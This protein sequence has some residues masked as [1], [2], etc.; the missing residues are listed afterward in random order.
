[1]KR[2]VIAILLVMA[3]TAGCGQTAVPVAEHKTEY[4]AG[5]STTEALSESE[6]IVDE[7]L[8]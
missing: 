2:T 4:G 8:A 7:K 1:M 3:L 6:K 5:S